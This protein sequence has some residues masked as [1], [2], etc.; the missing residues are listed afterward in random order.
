MNYSLRNCDPGFKGPFSL[1]SLLSVYFYH[2]SRIR[3]QD[4]R[5]YFASIMWEAGGGKTPR[6]MLT[7]HLL[8]EAEKCEGWSFLYKNF[9]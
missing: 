9:E 5:E 6:Q 7:L 3:N 8:E 1:K 2:N 4:R